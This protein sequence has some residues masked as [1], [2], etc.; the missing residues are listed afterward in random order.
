MSY[1]K[2]ELLDLINV[3]A[4]TSLL[5][6]ASYIF[7]AR[8]VPQKDSTGAKISTQAKTINFY[9]STPVNGALH[10]MQTSYSINCR[11]AYEAD[12][13]EI[14]DAVFDILKAAPNSARFFVPSIFEPIPPITDETDN[15]NVPL[16]IDS[17]GRTFA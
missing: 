10:Y 9:R 11:A 3:P 6:K 8:V 17:R 7:P 4:V 15:Y 12:A 13:Q 1:G 16:E 14:A 2:Q 5:T